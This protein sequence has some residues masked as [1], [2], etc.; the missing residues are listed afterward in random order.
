MI[1]IKHFLICFIIL[2]PISGCDSQK[3]INVIS[4]KSNNYHIYFYAEKINSVAEDA[5]LQ[6]ILDFKTN[7][8]SS[9]DDFQL[10]QSETNISNVHHIKNFPTLIITKNGET[11][12]KV[13]GKASSAEVLSNLK[14]AINYPFADEQNRMDLKKDQRFYYH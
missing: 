4:L 1:I 14:S 5:Y 3:K 10:T 2:F 7:L 11:V 8:A 13:T 6:A 12:A 9:M